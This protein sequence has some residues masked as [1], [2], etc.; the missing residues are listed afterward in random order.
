MKQPRIMILGVGNLLLSDEGFGIH[1]VEALQ[2]RYVFAENVS[3]VD[4]GVLGMNLLGVICDVDHL[5]VVDIIRNN[6]APGTLYRIDHEDIPRRIRA[7]NSIHQL[8]FLEAM[9]FCRHGLDKEPRAVIL[10]VEP[11]DMETFSVEMTPLIRA[12]VDEIIPIVL[13]EVTQLGGAHTPIGES[14]EHVL[15]DSIQNH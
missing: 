9:T 14:A 12:K 5:I 3:V 6:G 10:G 4:G 8:D 11:L 15:G 13:E 2:S 7:K 1:V